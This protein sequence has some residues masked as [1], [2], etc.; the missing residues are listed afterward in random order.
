MPSGT[1]EL[2]R[3]VAVTGAA[4]GIGRAVAAM[5]AERGWLVA[6]ADRSFKETVPGGPVLA[7]STS[8]FSMMHRVDVRDREEVDKWIHA[9]GERLTRLDALVTAAADADTGLID[10]M[11]VERWDSVVAV[12]LA[13]TTNC[14][15]SAIPLLRTSAGSIITVGSVLGR[16][17]LQGNAAYSAAK[18]AIEALTRSLAIDHA[19][20]RIRV[21]CVVPGS[22]DTP[23]MW[24]GVGSGEVASIRARVEQ[25]IPLGRI[26]EPRE[27]ASCVYFLA[28]EEASFVTG[29]SLVVDGGTLAK[30]PLSH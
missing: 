10:E 8:D 27:I 26:A 19:R 23:M 13:G 5:F 21:N 4:S 20:D 30:A 22:T 7:S 1:D 16:V 18:G 17:S 29:S 15:R 6:A 2:Q 24:R 28:S 12:A 11:E 9:V 14:C 3:V 25:E